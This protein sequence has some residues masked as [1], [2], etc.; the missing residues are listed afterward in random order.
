MADIVYVVEKQCFDG[1]MVFYEIVNIW[2]SFKKAEEC[3]ESLESSTRNT[4]RL[5]SHIVNK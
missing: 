2:G 3:K 5:T 1:H 4:Y